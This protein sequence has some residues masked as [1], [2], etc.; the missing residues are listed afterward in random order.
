MYELPALP[1]AYDALEPI[2][3]GETMKLHHDKH[4]A[5]YVTHLNEALE[6]YSELAKLPIREL[7]AEIESVPE[8]I[9]MAV[10]NH[11]GGHLNHSM[12]WRLM[13]PKRGG[14]PG[15]SVAREIEKH[16]GSLDTFREKFQKAGEAHFGSGWVWLVRGPADALAIIT[17]PNQDSPV[18]D[19]LHPIL[20]N[21]LWEHAYYLKYHNKRDEYLK[22]WW[23]VV[24]WDE[25]ALNLEN[26]A[27]GR[28]A[29]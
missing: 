6:P 17:T 10:R 29:A 4:H 15:K 25:V 28:S 1:Y 23:E 7:I 22:L 5:A 9:R 19:G 12:F 20:G 21:D 3:D 26:G 8:Q 16:F 27:E 18:M 2:I 24:N 13:T 14:S 11:G